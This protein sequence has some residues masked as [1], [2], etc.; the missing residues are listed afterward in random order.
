M[1]CNVEE[2]PFA[3]LEPTPE[4]PY[5]GTIFLDP[6]IITADDSSAF[7][8]ISATGQGQR[9]IYDRRVNNWISINA[10]LFEAIYA[11]GLSIEVQINPEFS[12]EL[13]SNEALKYATSVGLLPTSL[14][15]DVDALWINKGEELF[16]GGNRSI[17]IHTGQTINYERDG[18][19][20]ETLVHEATHTSL[21]N[22]HA[23]HPDWLNA[24]SKDANFISIY[25]RDNPNREDVAETYLLYLALRYRSDRISAELKNTILE[26]IPN[27]I[28]YFDNVNLDMYPI[29]Y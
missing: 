20:E 13:A 24:Q 25:A 4:P 23:S 8:S 5:G 6:D 1:S 21:D 16:G 15:L 19:L 27:R 17:L 18:I 3:P 29:V 28:E 2:A 12:Y 26:T 14:R 10:H 7:K 22:P 9:T 11:D